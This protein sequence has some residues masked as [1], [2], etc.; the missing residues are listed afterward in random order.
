MTAYKK[1]FRP[2]LAFGCESWVL[3]DRLKSKVQ[4]EEMRYL[5]RVKGVARKDK[6]RNDQRTKCAIYAEHD[7][8]NIS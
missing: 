8:S 2:T 3:I 7:R 4:A 5:R 6:I 1:M